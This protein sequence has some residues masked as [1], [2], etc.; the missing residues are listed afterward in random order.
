MKEF[1]DSRRTARGF[2]ALRA[3]YIRRAEFLCTDAE[4]LNTVSEFRDEW[5][6]EFPMY[7]LDKTLH[8]LPDVFPWQRPEEQPRT[9][10]PYERSDRFGWEVERASDVW[11]DYLWRLEFRFF[12]AGDFYALSHKSPAR[13][14]LQQSILRDPRLLIGETESYFQLEPLALTMDTSEYDALGI[15]PE[16]WELYDPGQSWFIPFYP[17][18]T[19]DDLREAI[20]RIVEQIQR[21]LGPQTVGARIEALHF[22]GLTQQPIA[23]SL[24]LNVKVV[25]AHLRSIREQEPEAV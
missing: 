17:G 6:H 20:P 4:Y 11:A 21:F 10:D 8:S 23:D 3:G 12:N 2:A 15:E 14:F 1:T 13:S 7:R 16:E 5:K 19:A 24:G 22:G 18:M 25:Q 9:L